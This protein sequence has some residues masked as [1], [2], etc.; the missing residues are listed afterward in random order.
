MNDWEMTAPDG[1]T[2]ETYL[3][4]YNLMLEQ[5]ASGTPPTQEE[6]S[7][8]PLITHWKI[9][10]V[11]YTSGER[12]RHIFGNFEGHPFIVEG[13]FG[14]TSPL[15]QL[16]RGMTW[17]RCRSRVYRLQEPYPQWKAG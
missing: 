6:L 4:D 2:L 16:D 17:A 10:E 12:Y 1:R 5:I 15:L 7:A 14:R 13:G 11:I 8:A 3:R 9:E